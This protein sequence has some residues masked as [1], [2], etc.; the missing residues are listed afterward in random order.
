VGGEWAR[1]RVGVLISRRVDESTRQ[2]AASLLGPAVG[3]AAPQ[4]VDGGDGVMGRRWA[5]KRQRWACSSQQPQGPAQASEWP[6]R[7]A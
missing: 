2:A 1:G 4:G 7:T 5:A 3:E 6:A